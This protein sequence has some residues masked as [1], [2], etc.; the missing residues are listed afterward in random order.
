[1]SEENL[2][3]ER[4]EYLIMKWKKLASWEYPITSGAA[5]ILLTITYAYLNYTDASKLNLI[6]S[7]TLTFYLCRII[8]QT[9]MPEISPERLMEQNIDT[10][11]D[12]SMYEINFMLEETKRFYRILKDLRNDSPGLF[13]FFACLILIIFGYIGIY[14]AILTLMYAICICALVVPIALRK[15]PWIKEQIAKYSCLIFRALI[16]A[17]RRLQTEVPS[18][19]TSG[20]D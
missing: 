11:Q 19:S 9:I 15:S 3:V 1:M 5:I 13:C 2:P 6:L 7:A 8:S 20:R 4:T 14:I 12:V 16:D 18:V 10:S 17:R